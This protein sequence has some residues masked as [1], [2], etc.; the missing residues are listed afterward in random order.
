ML[1]PTLVGALMLASLSA[2]DQIKNL[3]GVPALARQGDPQACIHPDT[4]ALLDRVIR[5]EESDKPI[6]PEE[7]A[8]LPIKV[9]N[10]S[11]TAVEKGVSVTCTSDL[12]Y[13]GWVTKGFVYRI[14]P[15]ADGSDFQ[16]TWNP[17]QATAYSSAKYEWE[18]QKQANPPDTQTAA[19][20]SPALAGETAQEVV[21]YNQNGVRLVQDYAEGDVF[22]T[23]CRGSRSRRALGV[24]DVFFQEAWG[25]YVLL[26]QDTGNAAGGGTTYVVNLKTLKISDLQTNSG[27]SPSFEFEAVNGGVVVVV[28]ENGRSRRLQLE[29]G[30]AA[31]PSTQ[32]DSRDEPPG[33]VAGP[34]PTP[35]QT[36]LTQSA[37]WISQPQPSMPERASEEGVSGVVQL[38]C[39]VTPEGSLTGCQSLR[40]TPGGYGFA[41]A[42]ISSATHGAR[43]RPAIADGHAVRSTIRFNVNFAHE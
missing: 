40:E 22:C 20:I 42:A 4:M 13:P 1:R 35:H 17:R 26:T 15:T 33:D 41:A 29:A 28:V 18:Q 3:Q 21:L 25:D 12:S 5:R 30:R 10:T 43:L 19:S 11:M 32:I 24:G 39:I 6:P 27:S 7:I 38:Q 8:A 31:D 23:G 2:C 16:I 34:A 37:T 14:I 36:R 9:T